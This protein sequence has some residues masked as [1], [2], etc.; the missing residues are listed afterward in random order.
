MKKNALTIDTEPQSPAV[1]GITVSDTG[2]LRGD[3][4]TVN[5]QGLRIAGAICIC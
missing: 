2:S 3:G 4:I 5:M 1:S